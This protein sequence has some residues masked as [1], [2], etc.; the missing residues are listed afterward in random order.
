MEE[1]VIDERG[2]IV[3]PKKV[4]DRLHLRP[5][6]RLKVS[7]KGPEIVLTPEIS[8]EAFVSQLKDCVRGSRVRPGDV[9][10]MWG[11][12]HPHD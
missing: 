7:I 2:R 11:A 8:M 3:M 6:Q 1:A 5:E 10:G 4:W 9:K 12:G